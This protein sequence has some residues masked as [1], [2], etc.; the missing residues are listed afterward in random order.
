MGE[1]N[2]EKLNAGVVVAHKDS[3]FLRMWYES[4]RDNYQPFD[5]DFNCGVVSYQIDKDHPHLVHIESY[6]LTTPS[7]EERKKIMKYNA[8]KWR[9]LYVLHLMSH[10]ERP[11]YTPEDVTNLNN[12][13]GEIIRHVYFN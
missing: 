8:I 10:V 7:F 13:F 3:M 6:R 5:W 9:D 4:Y 11:E 2:D 12:T 1:Q